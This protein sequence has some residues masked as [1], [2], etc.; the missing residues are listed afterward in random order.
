MSVQSLDVIEE[1]RR[2]AESAPDVI[3]LWLYGSRATGTSSASSDYDFAIA[4][5]NFPSDPVERQLRPQQFALTWTSELGIDADLLSVVDINLA[6]V[7]LAGEIIATGQVLVC[8]D[9]AR[10]Y[11]EES[12]IASMIELDWEYHRSH[13]G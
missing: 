1:I 13:Y 2:R 12:R 8:K 10:R 5:Q 7:P 4:F 3:I 9:R 11:R 6:P